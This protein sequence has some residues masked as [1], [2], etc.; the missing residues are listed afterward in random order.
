MYELETI[1]ESLQLKHKNSWEQT[2]M[3]SY[4]TAQINSSKKIKATDLMTFSWDEKIEEK[5]DDITCEDK[6]RIKQKS[7]E[8]IK[9]LNNIYNG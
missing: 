2:R 5:N 9:E 7:D 8:I 6:E 4:I 1:L 3:I